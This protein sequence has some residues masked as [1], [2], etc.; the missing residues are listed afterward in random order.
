MACRPCQD[1]HCWYCLILLACALA[2]RA[3]KYSIAS[4]APHATAKS[5]GRKLSCIKT[6]YPSHHEK[7]GLLSHVL[8]PLTGQHGSPSINL[9]GCSGQDR[10]LEALKTPE[11]V[12]GHA[13]GNQIAAPCQGSLWERLLPAASP[14]H[15]HS[16]SWLPHAAETCPPA[17]TNQ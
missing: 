5:T 2:S 12:L 10:M 15:S 11:F 6:K 13:K 16:P 9:L 3:F 1:N 8:P 14:A 4:F 7:Y 17:G